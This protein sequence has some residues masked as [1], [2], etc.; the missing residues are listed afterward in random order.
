MW[1][2]LI[3][4]IRLSNCYEQSYKTFGTAKGCEEKVKFRRGHILY[5]YIRISLYLFKYALQILSVPV[6]IEITL[7]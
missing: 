4:L 5:L 3:N 7:K 1:L 6:S 2:M